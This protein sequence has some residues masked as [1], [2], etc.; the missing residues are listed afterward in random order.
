MTLTFGKEE[1][2]FRATVT[3]T[4][5]DDDDANDD[6]NDDDDDDCQLYNCIIINED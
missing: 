3:D 1:D 2:H 5:H 6:A 4:S